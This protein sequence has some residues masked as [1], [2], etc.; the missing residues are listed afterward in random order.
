MRLGSAKDHVPCEHCVA[1]ILRHNLAALGYG[2]IGCFFFAMTGITNERSDRQ[3][4]FLHA[5]AV[6]VIAF[7]YLTLAHTNWSHV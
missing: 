6:N 3:S 7:V 5:T 1:D 4:R 2:F